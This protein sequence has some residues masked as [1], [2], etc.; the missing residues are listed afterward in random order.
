[1]SI[2]SKIVAAL[3]AFAVAAVETAKEEGI[4]L[5]GKVAAD[6]EDALEDLVQKLGAKAT[7]IVTNLFA[8]NSLSGLEKANLA[9]TQ[10]TEHA[11]LNGIEIAAHDVTTIIKSSYLAVKEQI[12][13]L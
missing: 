7:E 3:S 13:K 8:D 12:A 4:E 10:L 2:L 5:A 1:M 6:V 9:A 11:A